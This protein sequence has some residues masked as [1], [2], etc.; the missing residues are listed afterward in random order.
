M[1]QLHSTRA[2]ASENGLIM[3]M[4]RADV[5][6]CSR[7]RPNKPKERL[8]V[9]PVTSATLLISLVVHKTAECCKCCKC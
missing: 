9:S 8:R 4:Y 6:S 5:Q 2:R 1:H 7:D 3:L